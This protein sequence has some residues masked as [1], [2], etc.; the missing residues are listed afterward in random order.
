MV[1]TI[2]SDARG[3]FRIPIRIPVRVPVRPT[4]IPHHVPLPHHFPG[5]NDQPRTNE[6]KPAAAE[7][8]TTAE[9]ATPWALIVLLGGLAVTAAAVVWYRRASRV[10]IRIVR[11]PNG[12]AP[13]SVRRA[14]VGLELPLAGGQTDPRRLESPSSTK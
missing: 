7:Q 10:R 12:E 9:A 4:P 2:A 13:E 5:S 14:W 8:K 11:T 6:K 1:I 3:Q